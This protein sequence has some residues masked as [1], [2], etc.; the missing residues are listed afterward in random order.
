[1]QLFVGGFLGVWLASR[2]AAIR[3]HEDK[4]WLRK[5][6]AYGHILEA[7]ADIRDWYGANLD[8]EYMGHEPNQETQD[9]RLRTFVEARRKLAGTIAREVWLL[10]DVAKLETDRLSV[11]FSERHE[12][13]FEHVDSCS[14]EAKKSQAKIESLARDDLRRPHF[15]SFK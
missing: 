13:W 14:F 5:S 8:D 2:F 9:E 10:P 15:L 12:S 7:L 4:V 1:M 6:D 3:S 11:V